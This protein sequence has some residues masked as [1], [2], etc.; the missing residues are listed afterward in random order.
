MS[1]GFLSI[2]VY[3]VCVC[4]CVCV[5]LY[6]VLCLCNP[7]EKYLLLKKNL[8]AT[9]EVAIR[10]KHAECK[11]DSVPMVPFLALILKDLYKEE[12]SM[13]DVLKSMAYFRSLGIGVSTDAGQNMSGMWGVVCVWY[14]CASYRL[15]SLP[16]SLPHRFQVGKEG[17][18]HPPR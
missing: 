5:A 17:A 9:D 11:R 3:V 2:R 7:Q 18:H 8:S 15:L 13:P 1:E 14:V 6:S 12:D 16:P 4:V 10:K